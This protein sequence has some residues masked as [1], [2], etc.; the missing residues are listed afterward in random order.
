MSGLRIL[1]PIIGGDAHHRR[2]A[3]L[4]T[5]SE[6]DTIT[7]QAYEKDDN[8]E[9]HYIVTEP[10]VGDIPLEKAEAEL[11][12]A[13]YA[14]GLVNLFLPMRDVLSGLVAT[15]L[16]PDPNLAYYG[17]ETRGRSNLI[18]Y[19]LGDDRRLLLR[20]DHAAT[21]LAA[22][23]TALTTPATVTTSNSISGTVKLALAD[24]YQQ[25]TMPPRNTR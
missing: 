17:T 8:G 3:A 16:P 12:A 24:L 6:A 9:Y 10:R 23:T 21:F 4:R 20:R 2:V 11:F 1:K 18:C 25:L 5:I 15:P 19:T 22:Y 7:Y 14:I 13:G